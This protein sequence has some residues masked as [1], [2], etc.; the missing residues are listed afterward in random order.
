LLG[1]VGALLG[2]I[3]D[4]PAHFWDQRPNP[5]EWTPLEI[6]CHLAQSE[7]ELQRQPLQTIAR[8]D[9]P[10]LPPPKLPPQPGEWDTAGIDG[11]EKAREFAQE[12][13]LTVDF[14]QGLPDDAFSRPARHSIYGPTTL[15]EMAIFTARHD[16]L[17]IQQLCQTI[18]RCQ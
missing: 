16:Q 6:V 13:A 11:H 9:N 12:R 5:R 18:G 15:M 7:A 4:I 10:F 3:Q 14:L 8:E 2:I 1:D 17:H